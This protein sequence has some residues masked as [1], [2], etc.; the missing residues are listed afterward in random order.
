M[1]PKSQYNEY[2]IV[3]TFKIL[4]IYKYYVSDIFGM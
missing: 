1:N 3:V 2:D 4:K